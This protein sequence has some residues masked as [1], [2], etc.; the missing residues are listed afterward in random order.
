MLSLSGGIFIGVGLCR[1]EWHCFYVSI[2]ILWRDCCLVKLVQEEFRLGPVLFSSSSLIQQ[3][4]VWFRGP[5]CPVELCCWHKGSCVHLF[6][7]LLLFY[8]L[9]FSSVNSLPQM[10]CSEQTYLVPSSAAGLELCGCVWVTRCLCAIHL[11]DSENLQNSELGNIPKGDIFLISLEGIKLNTK[12][13][14][15][16]CF[17]LCL[18]YS[19]YKLKSFL[20]TTFVSLLVFPYAPVLIRTGSSA[21]SPW[22]KWESGPL[23]QH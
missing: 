13:L 4:V 14:V 7:G 11:M 20:Q 21:K 6:G 10:R 8:V 16:V 17:F 15:F 5:P 18:K 12:L 3:Q 23:C 2:N 22:C 1:R 19:L 9:R